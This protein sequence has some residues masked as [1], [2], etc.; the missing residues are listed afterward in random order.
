[1]K[2]VRVAAIVFG[3][4]A[5]AAFSAGLILDAVRPDY[6]EGWGLLLIVLAFMGA[7][8]AA[9][10]VV[11]VAVRDY[12]L[13]RTRIGSTVMLLVGGVLLAWLVQALF[14]H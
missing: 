7:P 3:S 1:V 2:V 12:H 4:L 11:V 9:A 10:C 5:V 8:V 13:H 6:G 14:F